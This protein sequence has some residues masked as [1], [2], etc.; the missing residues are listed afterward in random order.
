MILTRKT[1]SSFCQALHSLKPSQV[2]VMLN[3]VLNLRESI[4][5]RWLT[6]SHFYGPF[7]KGYEPITL[8]IFC[9]IRLKIFF[10][11]IS[12][13]VL[14]LPLRGLAD[15]VID[16]ESSILD[17]FGKDSNQKWKVVDDL[18]AVCMMANICKS[19]RART[20]IQHCR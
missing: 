17:S 2:L 5:T 8:F 11:E 9:Q 3:I 13:Q 7:A 18:M 15:L 16:L 19:N 14:L 20:P 12:F 1:S 4:I 10:T 6:C